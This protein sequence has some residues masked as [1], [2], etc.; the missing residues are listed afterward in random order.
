[1]ASTP[2]RWDG[3][4][5]QGNPLRWDS[6]L[7]WDG[8]EAAAPPKKMQQIRVLLNFAYA[9]DHGVEETATKVH[10]QMYD[11]LA[12][13][14]PSATPP[15]TPPVTAA[16]LLAANTAFSTS[17]AAAENG[18]AQQTADKNNKREIV[19]AMLREL[20]THVQAHHGNDLALLLASGF[21]AVSTN[22]ASEPLP[23]PTITDILPVMTGK[24]Q[25]KIKAIKNARA[26][27]VRYALVDAN[28]TPGP[29]GPEVNFLSTRNMIVSGLTP[30]AMYVFQALAVGGSTGESDWSNPVSHRCM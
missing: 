6:G 18:S 19:V 8:V 25:V 3:T 11:I 20:A 9:S 27:N 22:R 28:G 29:Y 16:A 13:N 17:I 21:Q 12:Y 26:Y 23:P 7:T 2:L 1:M 24:L 4:D 5:A 15:I 14:A 10:D 30:G